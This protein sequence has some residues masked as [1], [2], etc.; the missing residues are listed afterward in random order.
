MGVY[1]FLVSL[2]TH[3]IFCLLSSLGTQPEAPLQAEAEGERAEEQ[4][5]ASSS[6]QPHHYR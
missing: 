5:A 2:G 6:R 4:S 1:R 3:G